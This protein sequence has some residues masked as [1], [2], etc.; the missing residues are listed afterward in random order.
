[1]VWS[2]QI[3]LGQSNFVLSFFFFFTISFC[4]CFVKGQTTKTRVLSSIIEEFHGCYQRTGD[5]RYRRMMLFQIWQASPRLLAFI[6][7]S[8]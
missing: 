8:C 2:E 1:M 5:V 7:C 4:F 3:Q 6:T